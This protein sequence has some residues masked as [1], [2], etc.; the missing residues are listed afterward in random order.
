[1][2][3]RGVK[4]I[5]ELNDRINHLEKQLEQYKVKE[6][7][8][9]LKVKDYEEINSALDH[10]L[11]TIIEE[12]NTAKEY[13]NTLNELGAKREL[14][15]DKARE[16][17]FQKLDEKEGNVITKEIIKEKIVEVP[18]YITIYPSP[19]IEYIEKVIEVPKKYKRSRKYPDRPLNKWQ[20]YVKNNYARMADLIESNLL[21][22][23]IP[24]LSEEYQSEKQRLNIK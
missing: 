6:K 14:E 4:L 3:K 7:K 11:E 23:V 20:E 19:I 2:A 13:I 9:L 8:L 5:Q 18:Y 16:Y 24:A 10:R 12:Y 15:W 22:D 21:I 17:Y 1:M